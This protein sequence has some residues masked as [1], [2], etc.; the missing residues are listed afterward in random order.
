M[1]VI[2][3]EQISGCIVVLDLGLIVSFGLVRKHIQPPKKLRALHKETGQWLT[4]DT[5]RVDQTVSYSGN[6]LRAF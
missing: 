2:S 6:D 4:S 3:T 1:Y 5:L